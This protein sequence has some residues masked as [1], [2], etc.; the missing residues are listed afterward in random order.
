MNSSLRVCQVHLGRDDPTEGFARARAER[1]PCHVA[2]VH[3]DTRR[4]LY[5][6]GRPLHSSRL[7]RRIIARVQQAAWRLQGRDVDAE[8]TT[9]T[10]LE[11]FRRAR[12]DV[13]LAQFGH[14]AV[15]AMDA[16]RR[17]NLPLVA[18]FHGYDATAY[19]MLELYGEQYARL[20]EQAA[21]TVVCSP[22]LRDALLALGAP[23]SKTH[24]VPNGVDIETFAGGQPDRAP[25]LLLAVGRFVEKK[26]PQLTIVAFA[27]ARRRFPDA[28]L[29]MIGDGEL[30]N[31]CYDL[32]RGLGLADAVT[33]LGEQPRDVIVREL[34]GARAFVQ[35][36]LTAVDGDSEGMPNTI[37]EASATGIPVI[38]TRHANIPEIVADGQ[39][40][41]L[42]EEHDVAG[43][44][45]YMERLLGDPQLAADLGRAGRARVEERFRFEP[46]MAQL[47]TILEEAAAT[48]G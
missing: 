4:P 34:R 26:A 11:A 2:V 22:S 41:Y 42:V 47:Y 27:S 18:S 33:L 23:A 13:V 12:C 44:A 16:C 48:R 5:L 25:Q 15:Q 38:S 19:P 31:A 9:R 7:P 8:R 6:D 45:G 40:G 14:V 1:L 37:L 30:H 17:L 46:P 43:M 39:T 36:S 32:V 20:F 3:G 24:Y 35:H 28:R 29:R 21:G 10:Y